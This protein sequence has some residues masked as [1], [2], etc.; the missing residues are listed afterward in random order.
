VRAEL[1]SLDSV[2]A[3]EGLASFQPPDPEKF[4]LA[5]AATIAPAG[6]EAGTLFYFNVVTPPWLAENPSAKGFEFLRDLLVTRWDYEIVRRA[7][8]DLCLHTEGQD[9]TG[10]ATKLSRCGHWEFEDYRE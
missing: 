5:V 4:A 6:T 2:D 1:R 3:L 7:I 9:W 8:S 10:I